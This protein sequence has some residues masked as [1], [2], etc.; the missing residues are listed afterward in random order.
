MIADPH[1]L[2]CLINP[3]TKCDDCANPICKDCIEGNNDTGTTQ[4]R[5]MSG[6][7]KV[8]RSARRM[9]IIW[10]ACSQDCWWQLWNDMVLCNK[11]LI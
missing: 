7:Y 4:N 3:F 5:A 2:C 11:E 6:Q 10:D 9:N 8:Y 1:N